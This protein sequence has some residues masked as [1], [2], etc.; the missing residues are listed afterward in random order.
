MKLNIQKICAS[1]L[2]I[3]IGLIIPLFSPIR[4]RLDPAS[5]TLASHVPIFIAMM[6]SPGTALGVALGTTLGFFLSSPIVIAMPAGTQLLFALAGAYYLQKVPDLLEHPVQTRIFSL[7]IGIIH[8]AAEVAVVIPFYFNNN[9][10]AGFY[11]KGF[12]VSVVLLVGVGS[13]LHSMI[14]F[15]IALAIVKALSKQR[16]FSALLPP[17]RV[18][19]QQHS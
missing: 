12:F 11:D 19:G 17:Q 4:I 7:V 13:V 16:S 3:A 9:L 8:A 15:E 18:H 6:I 2:L 14:D 5:F 10:S 1:A